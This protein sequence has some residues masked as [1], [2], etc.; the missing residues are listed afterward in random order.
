MEAAAAKAVT[1]ASLMAD[2]DILEKLPS[3]LV[4]QAISVGNVQGLAML[5]DQDSDF[6]PNRNSMFQETLEGMR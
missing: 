4:Q 3:E 1:P 6:S 5:L 2:K